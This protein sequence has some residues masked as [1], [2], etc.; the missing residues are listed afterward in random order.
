MREKR[1]LAIILSFVVALLL[2]APAFGA[3][4]PILRAVDRASFPA[5]FVPVYSFAG[6]EQA[7]FSAPRGSESV[8]LG[9]GSTNAVGL[10]I[11]SSAY[12][13]QH[14]CSMGHQVE[15]RGTNY[16][17][18]DWMDQQG[19][20]LGAGRGGGT[21]SY[22]LSDC[23]LV[24]ANAKIFTADYGGYVN[25]EAAQ[26]GCAIPTAHEGADSD[27]QRPR[28]YF[29]FCV[30]GP[31]GT[32]QSDY[33]TDIYGWY[34]NNGT[35]TGNQNLWP[36]I[37]W[38][39]GTTPVLHMIT[40]E[41]GGDAGDPQTISYYR[42]V[43]AY[44]AGVGVW[45]AQKL[46]DTTM[47]INP[48]LATSPTTGKVAI[49]WNAPADYRRD[50]GA[51][52]EFANQMENDVW[53]ALSNDYGA[54][55]L[56]AAG[57]IGHA[58]DVGALG[59]GNITQYDPMGDWKCYCNVAAL[60]TADNNLHVAWGCRKWTDTTSVFR[61]QSAIFHWSENVPAIRTVVKAEWDTG[62]T[63]YADTWSSDVDKMTIA[64]CD[65]KL[66]ILYAQFGN[67]AQPCYDYSANKKVMNGELYLTASNNN[68]L[69]WDKPQN[70]TN[71]TSPLCADGDCNSD[72][73]PSM[74]R[75]GRTDVNGCEGITPGTDVLDIV[76]INDKSAGGCVQTASGI[77]T[78]NPVMWFMTECRE[79]VEEPGP[80]PGPINYGECFDEPPLV[81]PPGGDTT[82]ILTLENSGLAD[83][84]FSIAI[85][86]TDGSGWISIA[87]MSGTIPSGL[88]NTVDL[89]IA[90]TAPGGAPDPSTWVGKATITHEGEGSPTDI[91]FCMLVASEFTYPQSAILAT[92]C[93]RLRVYNTGELSNNA[94][95]AA[96]DFIDGDCDTFNA[97]TNASIYLYDGSPIICRVS[98]SDTLRFMMYSKTFTDP[99]G[100][101]PLSD[102]IV[103]DS[104]A[105]TYAT[106]EFCTADSVLGFRSQYFAPKDIEDSCSLVFEVLWLWNR[107]GSAVNGVLFGKVVDWDVPSDSA[108]NNG[109]GY[110]TNDTMAV[111][112][113]FGGEYNQDDSTEALC[114]QE[115]NQRVAA[116]FL[117]DLHYPVKNAFTIDNATYVY[118]SGPYG[119]AAP[120]P[121]GPMYNMM[122]T[123]EGLST[124]SST[125]PESLYTDLTS[126]VTFGEYNL[127]PN[128]TVIVVN[129]L[130]SSKDAALEIGAKGPP[131]WWWW[132]W[133]WRMI[134]FEHKY[135]H[136][137]FPP[138]WWV[139]SCCNLPGD[140]NNDGKVNV[141]DA[142]YIISY[143]FRG[144]PAPPCLQE[145]DANGD[146]KVN[147]GDAVYII[148]YVFRG[149]PAP[150][151]GP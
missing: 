76:Y 35:G 20:I 82:F 38:Q 110:Y 100:L 114:P 129:I 6:A 145:G 83:N 1:L 49:V 131:P 119:N 151:C 51:S 39:T 16:V 5:R 87:P 84:D 111:L 73:W 107:T 7:L 149:G 77:W 62:G 123:K 57:S 74:A 58:A 137:W 90:L 85:S 88:N 143:V 91:N 71:S 67:A 50:H 68:G 53:Y 117:D 128:D 146:G 63:C 106:S 59:G 150:I 17:H 120:L 95:D 86:Y 144:G 60:I 14:N 19:Y 70:L 29:D 41:S 61:R 40:C 125:A 24:Y 108:S 13:Y 96:L 27:S 109:S 48:V 98:G 101:R 127:D 103:V 4:R 15:H 97:N 130:F 93:V 99:D 133:I 132:R 104:P 42:R 80:I 81:I 45:S 147:V 75:Y 139:T 8:S 32:F 112:Y 105:Y 78:T 37:E 64:E 142:V 44:G 124:W 79:V 52:V 126:V 2:I 116:M 113:Q 36:I 56:T 148:S 3:D 28:A 43:G 121:P 30:G 26:N 72:M 55:F 54:S 11:G 18:M 12:D 22:N 46:V 141:G 115:S 134:R 25:M 138:W 65:G 135:I 140:A 33:P 31:L 23:D 69:N 118:T 66:Y 47:N 9:L 94:T 122:K 21:Q 10:Q 34:Q 102:L 136:P 92:Q 89:T